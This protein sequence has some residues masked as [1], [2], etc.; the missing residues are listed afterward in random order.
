MKDLKS[1]SLIGAIALAASLLMSAAAF[2]QDPTPPATPEPPA[3]VVPVATLSPVATMAPLPTALPQAMEDDRRILRGDRTISGDSFVLR[4]N[5]TLRGDL[6]IFGGNATLEENSVVEGNVNLFGGNANIAGTVTGNVSLLGGNILL[7]ETGV[8]EGDIARMGGTFNRESGAVVRG[9]WT[10]MNVPDLPGVGNADDSEPRV[11]ERERGPLDW[12]FSVITSTITTILGA[13]LISLLALAIVALLPRNVAQAA[14]VLQAN[15]LTSGLVGALTLFAVPILA[16]VM[17]ITLCLIPVSL[18][19]VLGLAA[20]I[21]AGWTISARILGERVMHALHRSDWSLM[22]QTLAGAVLLALLGSVPIIGGLIGFAA[23]ALGLGALILTR[24]GTR[25]YP[26]PVTAPAFAPIGPASPAAAPTDD[27]PVARTE[28]AA[29]AAAPSA[30]PT[31][32]APATAPET[33][34]WWKEDMP[35]TKDR[36]ASTEPPASDAPPADAPPSTPPADAP[37]KPA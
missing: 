1:K 34:E 3:T 20:A 35:A 26:M 14:T 12:L 36:P 37:D 9:Q 25:P 18:L 5:E 11:V 10:T 21:I 7:R 13:I 22:I 29:P 33:N 30:T 16:V 6:T 4:S 28:P 15:W 23:T 2:A 8:I 24:A 32:D 27:Q 17:A 19:L 31:S